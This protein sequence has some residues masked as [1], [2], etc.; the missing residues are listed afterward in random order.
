[1]KQAIASELVS[2]LF[3]AIRGSKALLLPIVNGYLSDHISLAGRETTLSAF[4]MSYQLVRIPLVLAA[5]VVANIV[6]ETAAVAVL[7][8]VFLLGA[9]ATW[10]LGRPIG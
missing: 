9:A 1:M 7:G 6:R 2:Q 4:S 10:V 5:G 8:G 3:V